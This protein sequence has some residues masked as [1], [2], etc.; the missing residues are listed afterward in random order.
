MRPVRGFTLIELVMVIVLTGIVAVISAQFIVFSTEGAQ[1]TARRGRLASTAAVV[2]E[3]LSRDIR[4]ALPGSVRVSSDGR[5]LEFI[6]VLAGGI[7]LDLPLTEAA[8]RF[9][10]IALGPEAVSG[11]I[12]VYPLGGSNPY[13][14]DDPGP[15]STRVGSVPGGSDE[16]TVTLGGMHRFDRASPERRFFVVGT[17]IAWCQGG[18]YLYRYRAYGFVES[19]GSL[20]GT[21]PTS[22]PDREVVAMPLA[23]DSLRFDAIPPTL[24]RNGLVTFSLRLEDPESGESLDVQQEVQIRNVP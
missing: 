1:D 2:S 5:C 18:R 3:W 13:A 9:R 17:P 19:M 12:A 15:I 20:S 24:T 6:P 21:L 11:R 4:A 14:L 23:I 7:Y 10:A 16:V 8:D 22:A